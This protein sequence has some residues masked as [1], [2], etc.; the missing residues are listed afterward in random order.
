MEGGN[1]GYKQTRADS[2][3]PK[4]ASTTHFYTFLVAAIDIGT[5]YSGYAFSFSHDFKENPTK[6]SV[7][8][9]LSSTSNLVSEK[10]PTCVLFDQNDEPHAFGYEA[11]EV[12]T[13]ISQED[14]EEAKKWSMF[15]RFKM[16]LYNNV[17]INKDFRLVATNGNTLPA[18]TV[19]AASIRFMK[20]AIL[21]DC[22]NQCSGMIKMDDIAWVLT[23]PAIWSDPAKKFMRVAAEKAGINSR[24]LTLALEPEAAALF[25]RH[26]PCEKPKIEAKDLC[27]DADKDVS[28][29]PNSR[30][31]TNKV[32]NIE[33]S[34]G[35][36]YDVATSG[37]D[38]VTPGIEHS[39]VE[40]QTIQGTPARH[41]TMES[42]QN[43]LQKGMIVKMGSDVKYMVID[44]GG[45]TID[46]AVHE[47]KGDRIRE[48]YMA[49]GGNWGGTDVDEAFREF[50]VELVSPNVTGLKDESVVEGRQILE[51]FER[52]FGDDDLDLKR[53]FEVKK[54]GMKEALKS[55]IRIKIP[56][57]LVD[58]FGELNPNIKMKEIDPKQFG[59]RAQIVRDKLHIDPPVVSSFFQEPLGRI[60]EHLEL[61]FSKPE[62]EGTDKILL[63]GGFARSPLLVS[64]IKKAFPEKVVI[65]PTEAEV[66]VLKGAVLFGHNPDIF[67]ERISR[68]TYG[69]RCE[70]QF[71]EEIHPQEFKYVDR[72]G[73]EWCH[74]LFDI[75]VKAGD[76][77]RIGEPQAIRAYQPSTF[78]TDGVFNFSVFAT[79][80]ESPM[81]VTENGVHKAGQV[82]LKIPPEDV[83][84]DSDI[85]VSFTFSGTE[86]K[87]VAQYAKTGL[88]EQSYIGYCE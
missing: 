78:V 1:L 8:H 12:F 40:V 70:G 75:H 22:N 48:I 28:S 2:D 13:E 31:M 35:P 52:D 63:V 77:I 85:I 54:R 43:S 42:E 74:N 26:I 66:A 15:R 5:T 87:A 20:D 84:Y 27:N 61:I 46:I 62:L 69:V 14:P 23:V 25:V 53:D 38:D 51:K 34:I 32:T 44:A 49:S 36:R 60:V 33:K 86:I 81:F 39:N 50:L 64:A 67:C 3:L 10:T 79:K 37:G 19:F 65:V 72:K 45:G 58:T 76:I 16:Q 59:G 18:S 56:P 73:I 11:E 30:R 21:E 7:K 80:T 55:K 41:G 88:K 24:R 29:A 47:M 57:S 4:T 68:Y 9:W 82:T 17:Q 71:I 6:I 83:D